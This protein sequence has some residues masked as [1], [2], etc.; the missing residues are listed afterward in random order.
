MNIHECQ[1]AHVMYMI[2]SNTFALISVMS[3]SK[4]DHVMSCH[5][6]VFAMQPNM[7]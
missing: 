2:S 4:H 7:P 6:M 5:V 3:R 1:K